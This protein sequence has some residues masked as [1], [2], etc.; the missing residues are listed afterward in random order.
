MM[1]SLYQKTNAGGGREVATL[2]IGL[3]EKI[4]FCVAKFRSFVYALI[5]RK[6]NF[7]HI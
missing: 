1:S 7:P 2:Q 5:K 4:P 3:K 6:P